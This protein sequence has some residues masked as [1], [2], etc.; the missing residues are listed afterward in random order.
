M[1]Q[2]HKFEV[3]MLHTRILVVE[4]STELGKVEFTPIAVA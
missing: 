3:T 1:D 2:A 4:A